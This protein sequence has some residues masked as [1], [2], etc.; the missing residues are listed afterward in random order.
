VTV[1]GYLIVINIVFYRFYFFIFSSV[2]VSIRKIYK[3]SI[4]CSIISPNTLTFVKNSPLRVVYFNSLLAIGKCS[5]TRSFVFDLLQ[6][7]EKNN[8]MK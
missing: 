1:F 8:A 7:S 5:Q 4:P 3:P 6:C 2:S